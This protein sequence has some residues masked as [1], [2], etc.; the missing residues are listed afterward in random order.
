MW[1]CRAPADPG[2][3]ALVGSS[4][5]AAVGRR[6][7]LWPTPRWMPRLARCRQDHARPRPHDFEIGRRHN[8]P[9]IDVMTNDARMSDAVPEPFRGLDRFEARKRVVAAFEEIGLADGSKP[10]QCIAAAIAA[11]GRGAALLRPVVREDGATSGTAWQHITTGRSAP[12]QRQGENLPSGSTTFAMGLSR[13]LWWG[14]R[15]QCGTATRT[16]VVVRWIA[17]RS[18]ACPDCHGRCGKTRMSSTLVFF[19]AGAISS[20]GW[21]THR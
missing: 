7:R 12:P 11:N 4:S 2:Y 15:I 21:P 9:A 8:L 14:H 5:S 1:R 6:I 3:A 16:V 10:S 20:I 19:V 13:Q 17:G 18:S